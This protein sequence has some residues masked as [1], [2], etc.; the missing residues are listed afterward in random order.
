MDRPLLP[1]LSFLGTPRLGSSIKVWDP[2]NVL[3]PPPLPAAAVFSLNFSSSGLQNDRTEVFFISHGELDMNLRPYFRKFMP[4][5]Q[6]LRQLF[7]VCRG[8]L[9]VC[10]AEIV[11]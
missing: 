6:S 7:S 9:A 10:C 1:Q 2:Y 4:I 8:V 3:P 5:N 11:C